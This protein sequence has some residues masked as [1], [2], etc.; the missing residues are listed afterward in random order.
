MRKGAKPIGCKWIFKKKYHPDGSIDKYK[1][2][3]VAK[4]FTQKP[5][6]D[7]FDTF[8]PVTRISSIRVLL[9]L[10]A[11]HKLVIHQMDVKTAFL[12]GDLEEKIYMTQPEGCVVPGQ[13][14]N[15]CKLLK[16]LHGL[17]QAPK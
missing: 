1:V 5:N 10:T 8:A 3:L 13:E 15:V 6:I 12:N 4:G 2:R 9:A 11:T 7:Y 17:K 16:S 14:N